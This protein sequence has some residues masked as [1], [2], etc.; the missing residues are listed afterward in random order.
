[1][2]TSAAALAV[3]QNT[4]S[5]YYMSS[6]HSSPV[7]PTSAASNNNNNN[8]SSTSIMDIT[9][10]NYEI[11]TEFYTREGIW[12]LAP[13]CEYMKSYQLQQQ[14]QQNYYQQNNQLNNSNSSSNSANLNQLNNS[15]NGSN[16]NQSSTTIVNNNST[17]S[18][19]QVKLGIFKYSYE[20]IYGANFNQ[21]ASQS[22]SD[23]NKSP[24]LCKECNLKLKLDHNY[25]DEI[26]DD[27]DDVIFTKFNPNN[28]SFISNKTNV[29]NENSITCKLCNK[30]LDKNQMITA[31]NKKT[32][33][34]NSN[35]LNK[36]TSSPPSLD[37]L[38]FNY[39][40]EMYTYEFNSI[41]SKVINNLHEFICF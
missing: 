33:N 38:L 1:M 32:S 41:K 21:S 10:S 14:Q 18:N 8:S 4:N 20:T 9:D 5:N 39:G 6:S 40:R 35:D 26:V 15:N 24:K 22:L 11:K 19:D 13:N 37:L 31:N 7:L 36:L 16:L 2:T 34:T 27:D 29:L 28:S 25:D 17:T 30:K 12:K 23:S 3:N